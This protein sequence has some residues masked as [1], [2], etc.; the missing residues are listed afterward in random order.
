MI[1]NIRKTYN[2]FPKPFWVLMLATVIDQ[3]G[4]FMVFPFFALYMTDHFGVGMTE[5]GLLFAVFTFTG[6]LGSILGGALTD[7]VGR[8]SMVLYGLFI[9]GISSITII[10]IDDL[11]LFYLAAGFI[12]LLG[13]IGGPARQAMIADLLP[14]KQHAEG[15]S[16]FRVAINIS[17]AIGPVI[18]GLMAV[19][20]FNL[21]FIGDAIL[22]AITAV[23]VFIY[24]PETRPKP[25]EDQQEESVAQSVKGYGRV[26]KNKAFML[27]V[28]VSVLLA[29]VYMQLNTALPVYMRD[30]HG[31]LPKYYGGLLSMNAALVVAFQILLTRRLSKYP[32]LIIAAIGAIFYAVGFVLFGFISGI[33]LFVVA[34]VIITIGEMIVAPIGQTMAAKFAP[35]DMRGRYLAVFGFSYSLPNIFVPYLM[36]LIMDNYDPNWVWY[37]SG[38]LGV[39]AALGYL[40]LY[41]KDKGRSDVQPE[42]A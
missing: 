12:G 40:G 41:L 9:S 13:N 29:S 31:F 15:Y 3:I 2:E 30:M 28:L 33:M 24:L 36:G 18:G 32:Q 6:I 5:V 35:E 37:I 42:H 34:M 10:L 38:V 17:A 20:S 23:I 27:F 22:S 26:F 19:R 8:K 39:M 25:T 11:S 1:N 4:T 21:L 16:I 7:K 14:E